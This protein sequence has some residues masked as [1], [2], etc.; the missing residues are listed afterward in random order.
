MKLAQLF[1]G[2][3]RV[4]GHRFVIGD[5]RDADRL[6]QRREELLRAQ[7]Q[8]NCARG[9]HGFRPVDWRARDHLL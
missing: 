8:G 9:V 2:Q 6:R 4:D 7:E 1:T 5:G 3:R